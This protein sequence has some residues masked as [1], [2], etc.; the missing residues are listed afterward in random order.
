MKT[1][2]VQYRPAKSEAELLQILDLQR[3]NQASQLSE[4]EMREEGFVT[5]THTLDMLLQ[6]HRACPQVV[7]VAGDVLAGYA[8]C[9]HP[10]LRALVPALAEMFTTYEAHRPSDPA[11]RVMGQICVHRAFRR[12]GHFRG[13]YHRLREQC[14]PL[15][16]VTEVAA[17]NVRSLQAHLAIGFKQVALRYEDGVPWEVLEWA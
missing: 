10:E 1:V 14:A 7:A 9:L 5:L 17:A 12:Q 4:R 2:P 15:P 3:A 13:L 11:Y 16:L 6:M 8:L